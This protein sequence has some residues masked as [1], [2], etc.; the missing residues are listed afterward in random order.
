LPVSSKNIHG[1]LKSFKSK[2]FVCMYSTWPARFNSLRSV[3]ANKTMFFVALFM[4][5]CTP[6]HLIVRLSCDKPSFWA[7]RFHFLN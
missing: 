7:V 3:H 1:S 4:R 6:V 5:A 2:S